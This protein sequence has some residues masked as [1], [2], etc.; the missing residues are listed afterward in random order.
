MGKTVSKQKMA[1]FYPLQKSV[2]FMLVLAKA[3][4]PRS[5]IV[6][7]PAQDPHISAFRPPRILGFLG[8]V[9][10]VN[11]NRRRTAGQ[12]ELEI[13]GEGHKNRFHSRQYSSSTPKILAHLSRSGDRSGSMASC[14][15]L[16]ENFVYSSVAQF[17]ITH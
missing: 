1:S 6:A 15:K 8:S 4:L 13:P 10:K 7:Y 12:L 14:E 16:L 11:Q 9:G 2:F 17:P 5:K 3:S